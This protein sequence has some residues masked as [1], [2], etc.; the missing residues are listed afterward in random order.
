MQP[1]EPTYPILLQMSAVTKSRQTPLIML[2]VKMIGQ[3]T[4][5]QID[6]DVLLLSRAEGIIIYK[7][8]ACRNKLTLRPLDRPFLVQNVDNSENIM[9]WVP[10]VT[11]Q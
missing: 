8:L 5:R 3:T 10:L 4:G 11:T 7:E 6:A 9:G 2:K 1:C